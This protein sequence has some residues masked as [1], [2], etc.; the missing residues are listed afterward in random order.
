MNLVIRVQESRGLG[1]RVMGTM[2]ELELILSSVAIAI[3]YVDP[4]DCAGL[5][6]GYKDLQYSGFVGSIPHPVVSTTTDFCR[7]LQALSTPHLGLLL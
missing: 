5:K 3:D 6:N 2:I 7:Y 1:F 4:C